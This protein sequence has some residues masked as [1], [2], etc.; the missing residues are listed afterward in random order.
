VLHWERQKILVSGL[1]I[2]LFGVSRRMWTVECTST[3]MECGVNSVSLQLLFDE[4]VRAVQLQD[5]VIDSFARGS[6]AFT[7]EDRIN[8]SLAASNAIYALTS[9]INCNPPCVV[10]IKGR[11]VAICFLENGCSESVTILPCK[12]LEAQ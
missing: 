6:E 9:E 3:K 11:D 12:T 1:R 4:V 2:A 8:A 7:R 10:A 5:K